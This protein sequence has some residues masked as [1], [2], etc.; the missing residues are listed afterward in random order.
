M[1][2]RERADT[3]LDKQAAGV[4]S[5]NIKLTRRASQMKLMNETFLFL[6]AV[7]IVWFFFSFTPIRVHLHLE[8]FL[9]DIRKV[10][11]MTSLQPLRRKKLI[12]LPWHVKCILL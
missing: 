2:K 4:N 3:L 12:F 5:T 10:C 11:H 9:G 1:D 6:S 8:Q 7:P